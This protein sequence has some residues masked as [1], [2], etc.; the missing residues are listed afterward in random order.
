MLA[1]E[2]RYAV[3]V[4][5]AGAQLHELHRRQLVQQ[6]P[7][8]LRIVSHAAVRIQVLARDLEIVAARERPVGFHQ[9]REPLHAA[10]GNAAVIDKVGLAEPGDGSGLQSAE[11]SPGALG[12]GGGG[13]VVVG[14]RAEP[15]AA[16]DP[17]QLC[18][19]LLAVAGAGAPCGAVALGE[20]RIPAS[21]EPAELHT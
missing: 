18:A 14:G 1:V 7:A 12:S 5:H 16:I 15:P 9:S 13:M 2:L 3:Q 20:L 8:S 11:K 10:A 21:L 17:L 19:R 4:A 6:A